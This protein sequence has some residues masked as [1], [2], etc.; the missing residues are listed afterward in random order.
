MILATDAVVVAADEQRVPGQGHRG[1]LAI[2]LDVEALV[3]L[4]GGQH[5]GHHLGAGVCWPASAPSSG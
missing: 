2:G 4:A 3:D 1:G 5:V